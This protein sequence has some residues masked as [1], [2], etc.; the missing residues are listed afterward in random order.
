MGKKS[1]RAKL[2]SLFEQVKPTIALIKAD[3]KAEYELLKSTLYG[4]KNVS[5]YFTRWQILSIKCQ[6]NT[7]SFFVTGEEDPSFALHEA[8]QPI[9][10]ITAI[11]RTNKVNDDINAG[12]KISI[13]EEMKAWQSFLDSKGILKF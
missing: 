9:H 12:I 3:L 8:L 6:T 10:P 11:F 1:E 4:K 7:H 13:L 2:K 5:E